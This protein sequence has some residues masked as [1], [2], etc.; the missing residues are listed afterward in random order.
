MTFPGKLEA[1]FGADRTDDP[2]SYT[3]TDL[4]ARTQTNSLTIGRGR[5][6][7]SG[8]TEPASATVPL[9]ATTSAGNDSLVPRKAD[10]AYY[11]HVRKGLIVRHSLN[12]GARYLALTGAAGG[13]ASTPDAAS[14]DIVGDLAGAVQFRSP[15]RTPPFLF[16]YETV[17]KWGAAGQ[18]SW[19]LLLGAAGDAVWQWSAD[20]TATTGGVEPTLSVR[21]PDQGPLTLAWEHD[22]D[23]GDGGN[24]VTWYLIKGTITELL[25]DKTAHLFGD[26]VITSGTTAFFSST[27]NVEIGDGANSGFLPYIGG[28]DRFFLRAGTLDAG[29]IAIDVDFTVEAAGATSFADDA[30]TPKTWTITAPAAI[31]DRKIRLIGELASNTLALPGHAAADT[32]QVTWTIA[33]ILRRMRQGEQQLKSA[34]TRKLTA[35]LYI[36]EVT[37]HWPWEDGSDATHAYSPTPGVGPMLVTGFRFG[38]DTTLPATESMAQLSSGSGGWNSGAVPAGGSATDWSVNWL[39]NIPSI[40]ATTYPLH[41]I[42]SEGSARTWFLQANSTNVIVSVLD[43]IGGGLDLDTFP[44]DARFEHPSIIRFH[45][46]QSGGNIVWDVDWIPLEGTGAGIAFGVGGS[47]AG[48]LGR[49]TNLANLIS[50][51][52]PDGMSVGQMSITAGTTNAFMAP[53]DSAYTGEPA[54][55]RAFRLCQ[56]EG[57]PVLV[58]GGYV[59]TSSASWGPSFVAGEQA[60]GPQRPS[61]LLG[62]L[63]ECAAVAEGFLGEATEIPGLTFRSGWTLENQAATVTT[64]GGQPLNPFNPTDDDRDIVNDATVSRTG[65]S[66][67]RYRDEE[68]IELDGL[69]ED[70]RTINAYDDT[71]LASRASW[72]VHEATNPEMRIGGMKL[73]LAKDSALVDPWLATSRGDVVRAEDLPA[74]VSDTAVMEQ[75]ID[76]FTEDIS[77]HLWTVTLNGR[78]AS[79]WTVGTLDDSTPTTSL[80]RLDTA[81]ATLAEDLTTTETGVDVAFT[82][83]RFVTTA[84][85]PAQFPFDIVVGGEQMTVTA[86][87]ATTSPQTFTVTRSVNG[88][89]KT[90]ST[91]ATV[92]FHQPLRMTL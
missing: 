60:M 57:I 11:P 10:S 1:A 73:E 86:I 47:F 31:T 51:A 35:P 48:T 17:L 92:E 74:V 44:W 71:V 49:V 14:L 32:G 72:W 53:A 29:T 65:G 20:G 33:G 4:T 3:W 5:R 42:T 25:A 55:A 68:S 12:T 59:G 16:T 91:G 26:P 18:R 56:E 52:P 67:A 30:A 88:V 23:N 90:H 6:T 50:A 62:A 64:T 43:S 81:G 34:L 36:G 82:G 76:G 84:S 80:A 61:T 39:V 79:P 70:T 9:S 40:D 19:R 58:D 54:A 38:A 24:T 83:L 41:L 45:A 69:Y 87:A 77:P 89:V 78:P 27:A 66:S 37:A 13:R 2:E 8:P 22:V 85:E 75:L 28:I 46:E 21:R 15:I 63:E 7:G